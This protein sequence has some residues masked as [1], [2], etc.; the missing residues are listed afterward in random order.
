[1]TKRC[2]PLD[3]I[4]CELLVLGREPA[5]SLGIVGEEEPD[6]KCYETGRCALDYEEEAP[7]FEASRVVEKTDAKGYSTRETSSEGSAG[8]DQG[9]PDGAFTRFVPKCQEI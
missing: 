4:D 5:C 2:L 6:E 9:D 7:A 1:M 8:C 3:S